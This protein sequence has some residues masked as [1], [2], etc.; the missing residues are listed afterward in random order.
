MSGEE[1]FVILIVQ[2]RLVRRFRDACATLPAQAMTLQEL[3]VRRSFIFK[4]MVQ[5][6]IFHDAGD[7]RY[8]LDEEAADRHFHRAKVGILVVVGLALLGLFIYLIFGVW[9]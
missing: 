6:G 8:Y 4:K 2:K 7:D 5:K 1:Q 3:G 9:L